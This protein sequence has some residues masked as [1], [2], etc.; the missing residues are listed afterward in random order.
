MF[1]TSISDSLEFSTTVCSCLSTDAVPVIVF[2]VFRVFIAFNCDIVYV[3]SAIAF[4]WTISSTPVAF[5]LLIVIN[6][7]LLEFW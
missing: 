6:N 3:F 2:L 7:S 1:F 4:V 5:G